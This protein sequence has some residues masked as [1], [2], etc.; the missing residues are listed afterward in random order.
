MSENYTYCNLKETD[1]EKSICLK[2]YKI[3]SGPNFCAFAI[4]ISKF[5][6]CTVLKYSI[7]FLL[8]SQKTLLILR[9]DKNH[10]RIF[11]RLF[12]LS[13]VDFLQGHFYSLYVP[14][15]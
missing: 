12:F 2:T 14:A 5:L 6:G 11:F 8:A 1:H 15:F 7:E 9:F 10:I 4:M 13:L 3:R